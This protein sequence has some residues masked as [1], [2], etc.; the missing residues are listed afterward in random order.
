MQEQIVLESF[1]WLKN[2]QEENGDD[3]NVLVPQST[4]HIVHPMKTAAT[5]TI[6]VVALAPSAL[7]LTVQVTSHSA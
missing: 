6:V 4:E 5:T 1:S 2:S 7:Y 3:L